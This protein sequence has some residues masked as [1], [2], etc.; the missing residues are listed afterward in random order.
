MTPMMPARLIAMPTRTMAIRTPVLSVTP[1]LTK[2][3]TKPRNV[4]TSPT[5][6]I[7]ASSSTSHSID[8]TASSLVLQRFDFQEHRNRSRHRHHCQQE[9]QHASVVEQPHTQ[10]GERQKEHEK[11]PALHRV[12]AHEEPPLATRFPCRI[13]ARTI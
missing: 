8:G 9:K 6:V 13:R 2:A 11:S 5:Y 1:R 3:T 10:E 7:S 12:T 4:T